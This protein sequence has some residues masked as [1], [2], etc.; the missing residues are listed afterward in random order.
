VTVTVSQGAVS[1]VVPNGQVVT[2]SNPGGAGSAKFVK[3]ADG[4]DSTTLK[5][6]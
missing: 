4:S 5:A 2:I 6:Q 1:I 3:L